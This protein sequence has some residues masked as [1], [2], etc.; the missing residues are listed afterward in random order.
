MVLL[1]AVLKRSVIAISRT[2]MDR[3]I[4][5]VLDGFVAVSAIL[6]ALP[7]RFTYET[8][9]IPWRSGLIA[10]GLFVACL[11]M[12]GY[13]NGLYRGQY[14]IASH[15]ELIALGMAVIAA[16]MLVLILSVLSPIERLVPVSVP[17]AAMA[18]TLVAL[19]SLRLAIRYVADRRL[20]PS[21][22]QRAVVF[23]AGNSGSSLIRSM[24]RDPDSPYLPVAM[25]D[26]DPRK[27]NMR[28]S[29]VRCFGG[30]T[31]LAE[32]LARSEAD[33]LIVA[34][35]SASN[36]LIADLAHIANAAG[37]KTRILPG[38]DHQLGHLPQIADLRD[39]IPFA[40]PDVGQAEIEA[41]S[42][43]I[44]SGW[45]TSGPEMQAF[46]H[47]FNDFL[48]GR[49]ESIALNS[50]TA[51]LHLALEACGIGPGDEVI[52][53]TWTFTAT[54]EVVQHVGATPV[55]VDCDPVT[56]N[57]DLAAVSAALSPRTRAVMPVHFAGL[58]VD[59]ATLRALVGQDIRIIEDAAHA[60]PS[61]W[62]GH[63]VGTCQWSDACVFSF[64]ATKPITTGE[65]GMLTTADPLLAERVRRMRLHG[66]DRDAF[67][68]FRTTK[69]GWMY[70]V[71]AA[72]HKYNLADPAA[73]MGRVQLRRALPMYERRRQI[74][75]HY[76]EEFKGL[77]LILPADINPSDSHA[78]HLFVLR[79]PENGEVDRD[80]FIARLAESKVG[81]SVHFT[82]LHLLSHW[83]RVLNLR[84]QDLPTATAQAAKVV[85]IPMYSGMSDRQVELV[86][87]SV[88]EALN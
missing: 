29:G 86:I 50:A 30:R 25:I 2:R 28:T 64:Y 67:H 19:S 61:R 65:G 11:W 27:S 70:D 41:V 68:R 69:A 58:P 76:R 21:R 80:G 16:S 44:R 62:S 12:V 24:L 48:G 47:D 20:R 60:L 81:T 36:E 74:A 73:A 31:R 22:A 51:G 45:V 5:P 39:S 33:V 38:L 78:W 10:A 79:L 55:L 4:L 82:P 35:P 1:S 8:S 34:V 77:P 9:P 71:V 14:A 3:L 87:S 56:L 32:T 6:I 59:V 23:G 88:R 63:L 49:V 15:D 66:I 43:S 46:E 52:V 85:S 13:F 18:T 72:G 84:P 17:A 7:L 26:D 57:L 83:S 75:H 53:P 54:A 42:R 37:V 40:L